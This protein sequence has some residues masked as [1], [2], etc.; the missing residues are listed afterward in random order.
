M[1]EGEVV[2]VK[3]TELPVVAPVASHALAWQGTVGGTTLGHLGGRG[4]GMSV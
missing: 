2:H 3:L 1:G 4:E